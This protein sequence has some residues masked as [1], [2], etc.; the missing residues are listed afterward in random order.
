LQGLH[1]GVEGVVLALVPVE[2]NVQL[3]EVVVPCLGLALQLLSPAIKN[4]E[5]SGI[6]KRTN[7]K[8]MGSEP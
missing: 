8:R 4:A 3:S 6:R 2:L 1:E 7:T 5:E